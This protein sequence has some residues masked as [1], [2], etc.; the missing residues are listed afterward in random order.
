MKRYTTLTLVGIIILLAAVLTGVQ[1]DF[2]KNAMDDEL[3][4]NVQSFEPLN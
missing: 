2:M 3:S 4:L 1:I